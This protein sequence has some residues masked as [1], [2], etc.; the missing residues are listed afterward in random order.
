MANLKTDLNKNPAHSHFFII[1]FNTTNFRRTKTSDKTPWDFFLS[2]S[3]VSFYHKWNG[4]DYFHYKLNVPVNS[5]VS[6]LRKD[7]KNEEILT[8]SQN[9]VQAKS[10]AQS[11][12]EEIKI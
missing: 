8:K 3:V 1:S 12:L 10:I 11:H 2:V 9:W 6:E 5:R 7:F 4:I